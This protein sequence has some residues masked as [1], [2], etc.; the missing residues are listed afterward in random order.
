MCFF[1]PLLDSRY[2]SLDM[3]G[4]TRIRSVA[5]Y[6]GM[7]KIMRREMLQIRIN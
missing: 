7:M 3:T 4:N 2:I 1:L 5:V 6:V